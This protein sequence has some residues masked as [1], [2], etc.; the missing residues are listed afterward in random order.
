MK[1]N[2]APHSSPRRAAR[3]LSFAAALLLSLLSGACAPFDF[4]SP[5]PDWIVLE[6]ACPGA[7][8]R[9]V[10]ER[11]AQPIVL[12][13]LKRQGA[14]LRAD[15]AESEDG[16]LTLH[17]LFEPETGKFRLATPVPSSSNPELE[18]EEMRRV[19][20]E[21]A[22]ALPESVRNGIEIRTGGRPRRK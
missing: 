16:T 2:E 22:P 13:R 15:G 9:E 17:F 6:G 20:E 11:V 12:A 1:R 3:L 18:R 10:M 5:P 7:S 14:E 8:E 19:L 21:I 4:E